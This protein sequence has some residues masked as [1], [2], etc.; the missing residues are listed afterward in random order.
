[1]RNAVQR[2]VVTV[3]A[4]AGL[5]ARSRLGKLNGETQE[6]LHMA[7]LI[8]LDEKFGGRT[9]EFALPKT[10]VGRG[11]HNTL[12]IHDN[13]VSQTH[14][15][16]LVYGSEVIVR[17]LG[18]RNGTFVNGER[19]CN[20]QRQLKAGQIVMFGSVKARLELA[21]EFSSDVTDETAVFDYVRYRRE[22]EKPKQ[23]AAPLMTLDSDTKLIPTEHTHFL[24]R[25]SEITRPNQP[26][27]Q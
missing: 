18:S 24:P 8:F 13:G 27:A 2:I 16:I 3:Q 20:Q 12:T 14:C 22:Q 11:D 9:Y 5:T 15:E 21:E 26:P 25:P 19:L 10:T 17:D 6:G 4:K 23:P 1:M 7:K